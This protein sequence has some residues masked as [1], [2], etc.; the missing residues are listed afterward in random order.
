MTIPDRRQPV[1]DL[2][3]IDASDENRASMPRPVTRDFRKGD[4]IQHKRSKKVGTAASDER[5]SPHGRTV[6]VTWDGGGNSW[7]MAA[8]LRMCRS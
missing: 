2:P 6:L 7:I 1:G 8:Q 5:D 4:R 3:D